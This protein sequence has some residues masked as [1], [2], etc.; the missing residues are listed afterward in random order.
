M[1]CFSGYRYQLQMKWFEIS[2]NRL[3]W[4]SG[5]PNYQMYYFHGCLRSA[6]ENLNMLSS[7]KGAFARGLA[8]A[9]SSLT[10]QQRGEIQ[11]VTQQP[12]LLKKKKSITLVLL[13]LMMKMWSRAWLSPTQ[14]LKLEA[15]VGRRK[16]SLLKSEAICFRSLKAGIT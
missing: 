3:H 8:K 10:L 1:L 6:W 5:I 7:K 11:C 12:H 2:L 16:L 13:F 9:F 14:R 15:G 4:L